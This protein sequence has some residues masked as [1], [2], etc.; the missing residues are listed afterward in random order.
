M[1]LHTRIVHTKKYIEK[2]RN[3]LEKTIEKNI[4][5]LFL[6][7]YITKLTFIIIPLKNKLEKK[8][9]NIYFN[10]YNEPL[11]T[12]IYIYIY[13]YTCLILYFRKKFKL[14]HFLIVF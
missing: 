9:N 4:V 6:D 7:Y 12:N 14:E 10:K 2:T 11:E 13:I 5:L 1:E 8:L 3:I